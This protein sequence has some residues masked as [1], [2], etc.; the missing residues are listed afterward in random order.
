MK[1]NKGFV[2]QIERDNTEE[3]INKLY[4]LRKYWEWA[5][6]LKD[7]YWFYQKQEEKRAQL[8]KADIVRRDSTMFFA[9]Y[10][11]LVSQIYKSFGE[12]PMVGLAGDIKELKEKLPVN[13]D[14]FGEGVCFPGKS[15]LNERIFQD[16]LKLNSVQLING[17]HVTLGYYINKK[18][19]ELRNKDVYPYAMDR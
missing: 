9:L 4:S 14:K 3:V 6:K 13:L 8:K 2:T 1:K 11:A 19:Q 18:I 17:L 7:Q 5:D 10:L 12:E 15:V 16:A